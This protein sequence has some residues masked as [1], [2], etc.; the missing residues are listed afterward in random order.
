MEYA[1]VQFGG[2]QYKVNPGLQIDLEG[3]GKIGDNL[4]FEKILLYVL[5]GDAKIGT[6]V[7]SEVKVEGKIIRE[8][9]GEKLRVSKFKAKSK[10]RKTIGFRQSLVTV[11]VLPFVKSEKKASAKSKNK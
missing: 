6:P 11:E 9:K 7:V 8:K 5:D 10:Y 4:R 2:K 1:V 3:R